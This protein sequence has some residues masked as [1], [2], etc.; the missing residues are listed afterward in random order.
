MNKITTKLSLILFC[1]NPFILFHKASNPGTKYLLALGG[2]TDSLGTKYSTLLASSA[3]I[4]N[5]VSQA[6]TFISQNG[7]D[8][9]DLDYEYPSSTDKAGFAALVAAL[10]AAF[11]PRG[12]QLT[13]AVSARLG[14]CSKYRVYYFT[15]PAFNRYHTICTLNGSQLLNFSTT[16]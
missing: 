15:M 3:K 5:F 12:W 11:T 1:K 10:R 8:G 13:A 9:L 16:L 2:W 6:V 7:F 14:Y 4:S